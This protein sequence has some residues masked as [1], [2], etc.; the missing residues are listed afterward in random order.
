LL[1]YTLI[2]ESN[3][4]YGDGPYCYSMSSPAQFVP[5]DLRVESLR[6]PSGV[7]AERPRFTW[8]Y[9]G[10][11]PQR[12]TAYRILVASSEALLEER[13]GD[14]WDS[15]KVESGQQTNVVYDGQPL[16]ASERYYWQVQTWDQRGSSEWSTR[17]Y[18]DTGLLD[19]AWD[20]DWI[21]SGLGQ[22]DVG[23]PR[24]DVTPA[25]YLRTEFALDS[26]RDLE[27]A[28]IHIAAGGIYDL[29]IDG[30]TIGEV[31]CY[32]ASDYEERVWYATYSVT[33]I[34]EGTENSSPSD[35][36]AIGVALGRGRFAQTT[37]DVWEWHRAP[38]HRDEPQ[39]KLQLE[40]TYGDGRQDV[41]STDDQWQAVRGATR[42]DSLFEG[43]TYDA[44][45]EPAGW[46]EPGF[47]DTDWVPATSV[48]GPD[49]V[50]S[51]RCAQPIRAQEEFSP[52]SVEQLEED[53]Y[54][55]DVGTQV[56]GWCRLALDAAKGTTVELAYG[57]RRD[58][59]GAVVVRDRWQGQYDREFI[60]DVDY[61][62]DRYICA[63]D[64]AT[65]TW[66]PRFSYRGFRYVELRG[67][68]GEPPL[69][70]LEVLDC[71]TAVDAGPTSRF[72]CS[73][74]LLETIHEHCQRAL[75][76]NFHSV[77][78]DTPMYE[79]N[80][81]T[82]D[83][84]LSGEAA[85][86]NFE[87]GPFYRKWLTDFADS[88]RDSG[89]V[90]PIV[91]TSDW[92]YSDGGKFDQENEQTPVWDSAYIGLPWLLYQHTGDK[93]LLER[94]YEQMTALFEF[95]RERAD[96]TVIDTGHGDH[97]A[98]EQDTDAE[99]T[100]EGPALCSTAYFYRMASL[101]SRIGTVLGHD[102]DA[103]AFA[104][105][106]S[107]IAASFNETFFDADTGRYDTNESDAG[108]Y[109]QTSNL[110]PLAFDLV[111]PESRAAVLETLSANIREEHDSHLDTGVVGTKQLFTTLSANGQLDLAYDIAT[112]R[113]YPSYGNWVDAGL[114]A[115]LEF[116]E[117][118]SRSRDHHMYASIDDWFY[119]TLAGISP[120]EPGYE[121]VR[122]A[123]QIPSSLDSV[124]AT[125]ETVR[126]PVSV[127]WTA[128]Q[129]GLELEVSIPANTTGVVVVPTTGT[130]SV[131][132]DGASLEASDEV[133]RLRETSQS[134]TAAVVSGSYRFRVGDTPDTV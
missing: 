62:T 17:S 101:L 91:P 118:D 99:F 28:A 57:E 60:G 59:S 34:L 68:P 80:G 88:Q 122:I 30:K 82:G 100:P 119:G 113:D 126:G 115:L 98:P 11:F 94:H 15:G 48:A 120:E 92:G 40:V 19:A 20:A 67:Y 74:P 53:R 58:D 114:S 46:S 121:T 133:D 14:I 32:D 109:R 26:S 33:E 81:W 125:V 29:H 61:Q 71:H 97:L 50:L 87:L 127:D 18:W 79:K 27:R 66:E 89:E 111:A 105:Y 134:V 77:P 129:G 38:W 4:Q 103:E 96:G 55:F 116:W 86:Y 39:L 83:A 69:E 102:D 47:D 112:Q 54:V 104:A 25:P 75:K 70:A 123:P 64:A 85:A 45:A 24:E 95:H 107:E 52:E 8:R 3:I 44:R 10:E 49:G 72:E 131:R 9:D 84:L 132:V 16:E 42:F 36:H 78:T 76:N 7:D 106:A 93:Q 63:G 56:T 43:E 6:E 12:Q 124:S 128:A 41:I 5:T 22:D 110:L 13:S 1:E 108:G 90:A 117:L 2:D 37:E 31:L 65:E 35:E 23:A 51:A 21:Q 130:N 73:N